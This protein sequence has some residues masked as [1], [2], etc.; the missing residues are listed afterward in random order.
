MIGF[1]SRETYQDAIFDIQTQEL[2]G[3]RALESRIYRNGKILATVRRTYEEEEPLSALHK[4][5]SLQHEKICEKVRDGNYA[6]IF[7][8][9]S[10]GI[11]HFEAGELL[12]ALE[13]FES[14]LA[15]DERNA[16]VQEHLEGIQSQLQEDAGLRKSLTE[17][18][19]K[20][21][22]ELAR[23]GRQ[24]ESERK[25]AVLQ[26][27]GI[28][29]PFSPKNKAQGQ[30]QE[31][32]GRKPLAFPSLPFP[33]P[34]PQ[35]TRQLTVA[36][37]FLLLIL[38]VGFI[39]ADSQVRLH[40]A[41]YGKI[42]NEDLKGDQVFPAINLYHQLLLQ[43][44]G[45]RE[46]IAGFWNT[47]HRVGD[48]PA[49]IL[50]LE[51]LTNRE[52]Q[53]PWVFFCLGEAY[54]MASR[55]N[56]AIPCYEEGLLRGGAETD[57]K[58]GWG[59]CLLEQNRSKE[60]IRLWEELQETGAGDADFR[61]DFCLGQAY[62]QQ[63]LPGRASIHFS[64]SLK[65]NPRSPLVYRELADCLEGLHQIHEAEKLRERADLLVST[66]TPQDTEPL[67]VLHGPSGTMF[68]HIF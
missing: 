62:L 26:R 61:V 58:I 48:Y 24:M 29:A 57:G 47:F 55:C 9:I 41:Y 56:D 32:P 50:V 17:E 59:L 46:A 22:E 60:A 31:K 23:S 34:S 25:R 37:S 43:N 6:L 12:N 35:V 2:S 45:S 14:V 21:A 27:L 38:C 68:P 33:M 64:R 28:Q 18:I 52:Q 63:G 42:A 5:I 11:I 20:R 1:N 40:P 19:E 49:A 30:G 3:E 16:E 13:C 8:W 54:R 7:L 51:E 39:Q 65:K 53:T 10:R 66:K 36:A 44:P 67:S 4:R 15:I